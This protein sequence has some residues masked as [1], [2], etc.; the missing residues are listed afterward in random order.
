[1]RKIRKTL[2]VLLVTILAFGM[3]P[4]R[5]N[6]MGGNFKGNRDDM[7]SPMYVNIFTWT[8]SFDIQDALLNASTFITC[9]TRASRI[10]LQMQIQRY[11][12]ATG[13]WYTFKSYSSD[14]ANE[15][16]HWINEEFYVPRGQWRMMTFAYIYVNDVFTDY[17][18]YVSPIVTW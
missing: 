16:A 7:I 11:D 3:V 14:R 5:A 10:S 4:G 12:A 2:A 17:D 8:N 6:A 18:W 13:G 1:M 15:F 9:N